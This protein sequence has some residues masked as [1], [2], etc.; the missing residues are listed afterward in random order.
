MFTKK[1]LFQS[2]MVFGIS[3]TMSL[4]YADLIIHNR[5]STDS[6]SVMNDGMCSSSILGPGGI[7]PAGQDNDVSDWEL[8]AACAGNQ[9]N[10]KADV[11]MS[12]DCS[13]PIIA[14]AIINTDYTDPHGGIQNVTIVDGRYSTEYK[15]YG[16]E[17]TLKGP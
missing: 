17:V 9:S 1:I 4:A 11:Y 5:T 16:W 15:Q 13:G 14:T 7:T 12:D 6:T 8:E 2:M 3:A 10:C